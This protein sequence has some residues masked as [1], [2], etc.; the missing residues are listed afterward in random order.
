MC[1]LYQGIPNL[2]FLPPFLIS[3]F[4]PVRFKPSLLDTLP[5]NTDHLRISPKALNLPSVF[6]VSD[7]SANFSVSKFKHSDCLLASHSFSVTAPKNCLFFLTVYH[8]L[9]FVS[10]INKGFLWGTSVAQSV[11][12]SD[13]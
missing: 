4:H 2:P 7:S 5:L 8:L 11:A 9:P 1:S 3:Y 13:S 12:L 10:L 6:S